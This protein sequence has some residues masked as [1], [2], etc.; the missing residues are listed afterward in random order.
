MDSKIF[1]IWVL[2]AAL[3][4]AIISVPTLFL[5]EVLGTAIITAGLVAVGCAI[6][7]WRRNKKSAAEAN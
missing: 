1:A 2:S 7:V 3:F 5:S 4:G 6:I